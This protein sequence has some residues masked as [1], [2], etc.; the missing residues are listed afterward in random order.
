MEY[1]MVVLIHVALGVFWAGGTLTAGFFLVPSVLEAG[2]AGGAVMAG[3]VKRKFPAVMIAAGTVVVLTGLR[4]FMVRWTSA[5]ITSTEGIVLSLGGLVAI[6]ALFIGVFVQRPVTMR[7]GMLAAQVAASGGPPSPEQARE[8]EALR[9]RL[10][11]VA[12]VTAWH[13]VAAVVLMASHRLA[14]VL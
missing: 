10:G 7:L 5:F 3:I 11:K 6:G 13:A 2:P 4:L 8:L 9:T 1:P 12:R 14:A